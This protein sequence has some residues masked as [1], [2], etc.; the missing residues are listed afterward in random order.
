ML[1]TSLYIADLTTA[2]RILRAY[3]VTTLYRPSLPGTESSA[4]VLPRRPG[5]MSVNPERSFSQGLVR[6]LANRLP[7]EQRYII[8]DLAVLT[9]KAAA[10]RAGCSATTVRQRQE[11]ALGW[12]LEVLYL[13]RNE[14]Q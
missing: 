12:L 6:S 10:R 7:E 5:Y 9:T 13:Q 4:L 1:P 14:D 8:E 11:A 2:R 3:V